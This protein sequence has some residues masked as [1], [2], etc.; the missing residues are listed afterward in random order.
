MGLFGSMARSGLRKALKSV[1]KTD[2]NK[3]HLLLRCDKIVWRSLEKSGEVWRS[4]EKS[5]EVWRSLE[6][7]REVWN[8]LS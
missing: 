4:L 8:R 3:G 5:R 6:K 7:S 1:A 2:T